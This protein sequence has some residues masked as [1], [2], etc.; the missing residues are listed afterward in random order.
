M[1]PRHTLSVRL[2]ILFVFSL[3]IVF[4]LMF[5]PSFGRCEGSCREPLGCGSRSRVG[6]GPAPIRTERTGPT[7]SDLAAGRRSQ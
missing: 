6:F 3:L 1:F 5:M 7:G 4:G 2:V